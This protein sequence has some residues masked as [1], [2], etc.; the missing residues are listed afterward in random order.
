MTRSDP[1]SATIGA[2]PCGAAPC[3]LAR[4]GLIAGVLC[5]A[6][7]CV[8]L[9]SPLGQPPLAQP[10]LAQPPL[11]LAPHGEPAG[12]VDGPA[13]VDFVMSFEAVEPLET[14]GVDVPLPSQAALDVRHAVGPGALPNALLQDGHSIGASPRP[15]L[16]FCRRDPSRT[17]CASEPVVAEMTEARFHQLITAQAVVHQSTQQRPDA[18]ILG[19]RWELIERNQAGDCEDMALTKRDILMTWGWPAGSLRPA[20]CEISDVSGGT[21]GA[22]TQLHAVLTVD[23]DAGTYVLGNLFDEVRPIDDSE[24]ETWVMRAD[25]I[26]W[27]WIEGGSTIPLTPVVASR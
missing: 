7:A 18:A 6:A 12:G 8:P 22:K 23:T 14:G 11:A 25:G 20:I 21:D 1:K 2:I 5:L 10:P 15:W 17:R 13:S 24:C 26:H 9:Q 4:G 27:S 16:E 3:A 19:D